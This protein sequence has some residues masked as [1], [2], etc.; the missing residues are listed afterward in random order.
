MSAMRTDFLQPPQQEP[1]RLAALPEEVLQQSQTEPLQMSYKSNQEEVE[2]PS[3]HRGGK[4]RF[5]LAK[6][7]ER[8]HAR[9][10][11]SEDQLQ[12]LQERHKEMQRKHDSVVEEVDRLKSEKS[13]SIRDAKARRQVL[14]DRVKVATE[15][16]KVEYENLLQTKRQQTLPKAK[17]CTREALSEVGVLKEKVHLSTFWQDLMYSV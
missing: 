11:H 1:V 7:L 2:A 9:V 16:L 15:A 12:G 5:H 6:E 8:I 10:M 3:N 17:S 14:E 13:R 4:K